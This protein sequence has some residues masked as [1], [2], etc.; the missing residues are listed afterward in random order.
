MVRKGGGRS[1]FMKAQRRHADDAAEQG[2]P[3]SSASAAVA[4]PAD[5]AITKLPMAVA[6][7]EKSPVASSKARAFLLDSDAEDAAAE[8][9]ARDAA[10]HAHTLGPGGET[11]GQLVQRHKRVRCLG[12]GCSRHA[13]HHV[14]GAESSSISPPTPCRSKRR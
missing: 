12:C 6:D 2:G 8:G 10:V 9:A 5:E 1:G 3:A 11:R 7:P 13:W 14:A 4:G